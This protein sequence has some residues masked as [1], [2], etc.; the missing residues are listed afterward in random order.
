[1]FVRPVEDLCHLHFKCGGIKHLAPWPSIE[2][3][4]IALLDLCAS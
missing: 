4:I 1:M 2:K 3:V